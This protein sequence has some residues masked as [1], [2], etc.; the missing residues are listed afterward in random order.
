MLKAPIE[1]S[2]V[3]NCIILSAASFWYPLNL[4]CLI[5]SIILKCCKV[6]FVNFTLFNFRETDISG[7]RADV[8]YRC[9][10]SVELLLKLGY[11]EGQRLLE[12]MLDKFDVGT[13]ELFISVEGGNPLFVTTVF[14]LLPKKDEKWQQICLHPYAVWRTRWIPTLTW[15]LINSVRSQSPHIKTKSDISTLASLMKDFVFYGYDCN[16][17]VIGKRVGGDE[18]KRLIFHILRID[19]KYRTSE[20]LKTLLEF[21]HVSLNA[22]D[23]CGR[24]PI[25]YI[26]HL[27]DAQCLSGTE[28][29]NYCWKAKDQENYCSRT[30]ELLLNHGADASN[31]KF[32][33]NIKY[34]FGYNNITRLLFQAGANIKSNIFEAGVCHPGF[35]S[36]KQFLEEI[37]GLHQYL[38]DNK[39]NI[40]LKHFSR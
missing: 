24:T 40:S 11:P 21:G 16:V 3:W 31:L 32:D 23:D 4:Q 28:T 2:G 26:L 19:F 17:S 14:K 36:T 18:T 25:E 1:N 22:V 5:F 29:N 8:T 12:V 35:A 13:N 30:I 38:Q 20:L 7:S 10:N 33:G 15:L 39:N 6:N 34:H 27:W 37:Q 9:F